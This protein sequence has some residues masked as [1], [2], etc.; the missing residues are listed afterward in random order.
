[1]LALAL[2][3]ACA[4]APDDDA[5]S[6]FAVA[7]I[8]FEPGPGAGF[9]QDAM[10]DIVLGPPDGGFTS[11]ASTDVVSLGRGGVIVLEMGTEFFDG[12]GLDLLVF[13]NPFEIAGTS[14]GGVFSEPG[15][16]AVSDDGEAWKS[17]AC[18]PGAEP[19]NGCAGYGPVLA[20]S[21][22]DL[23][24]T[25]PDVAGGDGFDLADLGLERARFVRITDRGEG[26]SAPT[27]GFDLD[28]V[29]VVSR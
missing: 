11:Q 4:G 26:A 12:D 8:S 3:A 20:G 29:A 6:P 14:G 16:V 18:D 17:F 19:P 7:V 23:D 25:D 21:K 27:A 15:E 13:E 5:P 24:P 1:M 2:G 9:G 28:A 22:N 10:P